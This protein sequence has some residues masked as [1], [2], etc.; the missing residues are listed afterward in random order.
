M[1]ILSLTDRFRIAPVAGRE[2]G[3]HASERDVDILHLGVAEQ[4]LN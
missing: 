4:F 2:C 3:S 1:G